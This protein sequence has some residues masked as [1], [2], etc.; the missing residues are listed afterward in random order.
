MTNGEITAAEHFDSKAEVE[1]YI[2]TLGIRSMFF[3][4]AWYMQNNV[5][6]MRP[7]LV[8]D[9]PSTRTTKLLASNPK[10]GI[11]R[12]IRVVV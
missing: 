5:S 12:K 1:N 7:Q 10:T 9:Y 11:S 4:A 6:F 2:R 8:S 3:M